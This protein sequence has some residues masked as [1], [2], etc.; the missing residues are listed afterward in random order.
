MFTADKID[1]NELNNNKITHILTILD[2]KPNYIDNNRTYLYI[3]AEDLQSTDLLTNDFE[4]CFQFIDNTIEQG[5]Q[6]LIHCQSGISRSA[7]ITAM[8]L[9]RK[10]SLTRE[11][12]IERLIEKR[13]NWMIMPNDGFLKQLDLFYQMNYKI[14]KENQ[15][16]Q[17]FQCKRFDLIEQKTSTSK[18]IL[19]DENEKEYKCRN[20]HWK[21]FTNNDIQ[22]HEENSINICDN[23]TKIFTYFL[24]WI[25]DIFDN[26]FGKI[27]CPNC[28]IILGE[29]SLHGIQ[30]NCHQWIKPAFVFQCQF[31][32]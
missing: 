15:L 21:L 8:Y 16:Y 27:I 32:E 2:Y 31:I 11:Q 7:T 6:I 12:A 3:Y 25:D 9:M 30:C 26:S 22:I 19:N 1:D 24:D 10:Y 29:Y 4:K 14:D 23:K 17:E 18:F 5:H 20:F 28:K 13:H